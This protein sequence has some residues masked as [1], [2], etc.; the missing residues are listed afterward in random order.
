MHATIRYGL[1]GAWA[2][3]NN[4]NTF[5]IMMWTPESITFA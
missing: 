2:G 4:G 5:F 1:D 3:A